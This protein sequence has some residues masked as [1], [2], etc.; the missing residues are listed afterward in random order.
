MYHEVLTTVKPDLA[1]VGTGWIGYNRMKALVDEGICNP[2]AIFEPDLDNAGRAFKLATEATLFRD[3][4][5]MLDSNPDGIVIASPNAL[6]AN[7][8]ISAL[9]RG[10]PVFCQ[11]P[12]GRSAEETAKVISEA[13]V[14]NRLL[15]VD[16]SYRYTS[17]MQKLY[18]QYRNDIGRIHAIDLV[19]NNAYGPDKDWFYNQKI[20]GGGCLLDLG[21]HLIDLAL[22]ML[23]FPEVRS[24]SSVLFSKGKIIEDNDSMIEDF[25]SAQIETEDGVL[26]RLV[27]SWNLP[28][29]QD[30]EIKASFYGT[31]LAVLFYNIGGSFY[32]FETA[33]CRKTER[34]IISMPPDDWGGRALI[35]WTRD[36]Q[37]NRHFRKDA[38]KYYNT[39]EVVDRIYRRAPTLK[40]AWYES[41]S[42]H[43]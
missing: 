3:F 8:C 41:T 25:V 22:W 2:V 43:R 37:Q 18:N 23:D 12:L 31:E 42:Y 16:M 27:C 19:F 28:A 21:V 29:G 34:E 38:F 4:D 11:K 17:G 30:A 40:P 9:Q 32:D 5:D 1:F 6:H 33:I 36:I 10:I 24:I 15:G 39:S 14:S 35:Q 13:Y 7:Q 26:I 20:S